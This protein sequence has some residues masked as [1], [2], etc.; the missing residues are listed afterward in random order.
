MKKTIQA[1]GSGINASVLSGGEVNQGEP[2]AETPARETTTSDTGSK[3]K[4][5]TLSGAAAVA[6]ALRWVQEVVDLKDKFDRVLKEAFEE[7]K[8]LQMAM[9]EVGP[10]ACKLMIRIEWLTNTHVGYAGIS[11][12]HQPEPT[13][14]RVHLAIHRRKPQERAQGGE[15]QN[16]ARETVISVSH[17]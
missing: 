16:L 2:T 6:A 14:S 7:N 1:R 15:F 13:V 9:N 17:S 4:K 3:P 5:P 10:A 8:G 11:N 12:V